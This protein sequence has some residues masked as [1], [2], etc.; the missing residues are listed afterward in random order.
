MATKG[1]KGRRKVE[2]EFQPG[3][4]GFAGTE[5]PPVKLD[6]A[7]D[8]GLRRKGAVALGR[9]IA[10]V[11]LTLNSSPHGEG[12]R[13]H[14]LRFFETAGCKRCRRWFTAHEAAPLL[15][16]SLSS[17][18]NGGEGGRR[19]GEEAAPF[20]G[21]WIAAFRGSWFLAPQAR[22]S[23]SRHSFGAKPS[24]FFSLR[25]LVAN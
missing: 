22:A 8:G 16:P 3:F 13:D 24:P 6:G 10:A 25:P 11:S 2:Q 15:S 9:P 20:R 12:D 4:R 19:P 23:L 17:I 1:H 18:S 14:R 5:S 21:A 7:V